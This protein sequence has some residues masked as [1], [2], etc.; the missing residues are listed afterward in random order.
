M[1]TLGRRIFCGIVLIVLLATPSVFAAP[2]DLK[3]FQSYLTEKD[4]D[5]VAVKMKEFFDAGDLAKVVEGTDWVE[6]PTQLPEY[7][8]VAEKFIQV[9]RDRDFRTLKWK[10]AVQ[11]KEL[12]SAMMSLWSMVND[13]RKKFAPELKF[14]SVAGLVVDA[15]QGPVGF[16][17]LL[18]EFLSE[19]RNRLGTVPMIAVLDQYFL[20]PGTPVFVRDFNHFHFFSLLIHLRMLAAAQALVVGADEQT[21]HQETIE[22]LR[23]RVNTEWSRNFRQLAG[24]K[25]A[26][27][28]DKT[29]QQLFEILSRELF[30]TS[31]PEQILE[32]LW[33]RL[34][35]EAQQPELREHLL[36][37]VEAFEQ[38]LN[39]AKENR[40]SK[41]V[42]FLSSAKEWANEIR[43]NAVHLVRMDSILNVVQAD[44]A[45]WQRWS[46]SLA[47][48]ACKVVGIPGRVYCGVASMAV[49]SVSFF[50]SA[51]K[52]GGADASVSGLCENYLV[53]SPALRAANPASSL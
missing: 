23:V 11:L 19:F 53:R 28:P 38:L 18:R 16:V 5:T 12:Y 9:F 4:A 37:Q 32:D 3:F 13:V 26:G 47:S 44:A 2:F 6:Y 33:S 49:G 10:D 30:A 31:Q 36:E 21:A 20:M 29:S 46:R 35:T 15:G 7:L 22:A 45:A 48:G 52:K 14:S 24:L 27:V 25:L 50:E 51:T 8:P 17:G 39:T 42:W 1:R 41:R 40:R 34:S 43:G